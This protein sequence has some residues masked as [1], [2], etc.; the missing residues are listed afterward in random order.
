[1][2]EKKYEGHDF[3]AYKT[4][5]RRWCRI[6]E[7]V[8]LSRLS[9]PFNDRQHLL[10]GSMPFPVVSQKLSSSCHTSWGTK[11]NHPDDSLLSHDREIAIF[12]KNSQGRTSE[13]RR[14]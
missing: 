1:M 4:K 13:Q 12:V 14:Q 6:E 8:M 7:A 10:N 9:Y 11:T 3:E 2:L 5:T